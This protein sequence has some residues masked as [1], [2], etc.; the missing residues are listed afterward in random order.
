L[1][2]ESGEEY[3]DFI[4]KSPA[5]KSKLKA[6]DPVEFER[7]REQAISE[8]EKLCGRQTTNI[9]TFEALCLIVKK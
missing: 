7:V 5:Y 9:D 8:F 2:F 1:Y 3:F 6:L 4:S